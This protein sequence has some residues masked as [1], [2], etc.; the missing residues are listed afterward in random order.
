MFQ[1]VLTSLFGSR[2]QRLLKQ[3]GKAV[4]QINVLEPSLVEFTDDA[5]RAKTVE[6]RERV[7]SETAGGKD[8]AQALQDLLP[9]AFAVCREGAKRSLGMRHFDVQLVG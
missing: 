8:L 6:F 5:L 9:E 2:N 7:A 1:K 4:E 3:Y